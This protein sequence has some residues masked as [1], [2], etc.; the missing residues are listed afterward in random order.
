[1][2]VSA[3]FSS[4]EFDCHDG[5]LY[6]AEWVQDRLVPLCAVL[7]AI[8]AA[9]GKPVI[10]VSGYRSPAYNAARARNSSGVAKDSQHLHGR[11]A[12]IRVAGVP[13]AEVH[14]AVL[15]LVKAGQLPKLGGLGIYRG[16]VH[17]DVRE[18]VDG[19]LARWTG[20][21]VEAVA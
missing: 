13:S 5:T 21:G 19:H 3:H 14:A 10:V 6:P 8:R 20:E 7:E 18:K 17:V 9:M 2:Q 11:A 15:A 4:R 16:W 1:M 12:D